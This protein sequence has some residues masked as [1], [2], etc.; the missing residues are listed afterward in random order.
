MDTYTFLFRKQ[1][2]FSLPSRATSTNRQ[3]LPL[4]DGSAG[5]CASSGLAKTH[6][7]LG[8]G[9][10]YNSRSQ[11]SVQ[12]QRRRLNFVETTNLTFSVI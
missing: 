1:T 6:R 12:S 5:Q 4:R 8:S 7:N 3:E 11:N 9:P 10:T 2:G